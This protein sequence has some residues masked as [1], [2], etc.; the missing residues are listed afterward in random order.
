MSCSSSGIA[1]AAAMST[2][3]SH[4]EAEASERRERRPADVGSWPG[5]GRLEMTPVNE[6]PPVGSH[7][8]PVCPAGDVVLG[9]VSIRVART[10]HPLDVGQQRRE[11][12]T[13]PDRVA[14]LPGPMG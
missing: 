3:T 1:S 9:P 2:K 7:R 4:K 8:S 14:R 10:E 5:S 13:G 12:L 11:Q 6:L